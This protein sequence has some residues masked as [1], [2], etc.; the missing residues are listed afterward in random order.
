VPLRIHLNTGPLSGPE[1]VPP[2][3][4]D[5]GFVLVVGL[6]AF[7]FLVAVMLGEWLAGRK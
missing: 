2:M 1:R 4:D 6:I 7:A 3:Y 5:T